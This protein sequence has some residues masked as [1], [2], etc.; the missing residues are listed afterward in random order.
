MLQLLWFTQLLTSTNDKSNQN[1]LI[2]WIT[3]I[4]QCKMSSLSWTRELF[5][6]WPRKRVTVTSR[7]HRDVSNLQQHD[8]AFATEWPLD[9]PH[10]GNA[11]FVYFSWRHYN[12]T[13]C[14]WQHIIIHAYY[15]FRYEQP[16]P[17]INC[18]RIYLVNISYGVLMQ[19]DMDYVA[20]R[21]KFLQ[22]SGT[23]A[24]RR[25]EGTNISVICS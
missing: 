4:L 20:K 17:I 16:I 25:Y 19:G 12:W 10:K 18:M 3:R 7:K 13:T 23:D 9:C 6:I 1:A 22:A 8:W 14:I 5:H 15:K 24:W 11:E 21:C 2:H